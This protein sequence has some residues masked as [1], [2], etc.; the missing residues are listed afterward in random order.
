MIRNHFCTFK[1][2]LTPEKYILNILRKKIHQLDY[3]ENK[4]KCES[5]INQ[6]FKNPATQGYE[7]CLML[8]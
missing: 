6:I 3:G 7:E 5:L 2:S 4:N 8:D 1:K